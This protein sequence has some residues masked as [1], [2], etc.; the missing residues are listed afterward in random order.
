MAGVGL[1]GPDRGLFAKEGTAHR[2]DS[3]DCRIRA[4]DARS[5]PRWLRQDV[6]CGEHI[7]TRGVTSG[8]AGGV[9]PTFEPRMLVGVK[10]PVGALWASCEDTW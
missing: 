5:V 10:K 2:R 9:L 1:T 8:D 7:V 6:I 4:Q 3:R